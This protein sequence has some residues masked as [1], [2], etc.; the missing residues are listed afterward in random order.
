LQRMPFRASQGR[1]ASAVYSRRAPLGGLGASLES[2]RLTAL[3]P[4]RRATTAPLE[5]QL[6]MRCHAAMPP[7]TALRALCNRVSCATGTTP[8]VAPTLVSR[9][10]TKSCVER[11]R[12]AYLAFKHTARSGRSDRARACRPPLAPG[13]AA[14]ATSAQL[15]RSQAPLLRVLPA[16]FAPRVSAIHAPK[17]P[18]ALMYACLRCCTRH[19]VFP[20]ILTALWRV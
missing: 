10:L 4:V 16:F 1:T 14:Q 5:A 2:P 19:A 8:P 15:G 20:V 9:A 18:T 13:A 3:Q 6:G 11:V 7:C 12:F 17:A